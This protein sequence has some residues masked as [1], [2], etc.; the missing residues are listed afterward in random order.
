M[1]Y[2]TAAH[3]II[4]RDVSAGVTVYFC[5]LNMLSEKNKCLAIFESRESGK[6]KTCCFNSQGLLQSQ[7]V[8]RFRK[9]EKVDKCEM[10][11]NAE[12][13]EMRRGKNA[14]G[15]KFLVEFRR[16][17]KCAYS[18]L[19]ISSEINIFFQ[20]IISTNPIIIPKNG[21]NLFFIFPSRKSI[22][23]PAKDIS[24]LLLRIAET[25]ANLA[26]GFESAFI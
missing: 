10:K 24:T 2:T 8:L 17:M 3:S 12:F 1:W 18:F 11:F 7:N 21:I 25:S 22:A 16:E 26:R 6:I 9:I 5:K 14:E 23:P 13:A 20:N 19:A 15:K 4:M